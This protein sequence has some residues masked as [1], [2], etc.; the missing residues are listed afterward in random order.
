MRER[1]ANLRGVVV[2][3]LFTLGGV[4]EP[5]ATDI[6]VLP[7]VLVTSGAL[8]RGGRGPPLARD[9]R[10][11]PRWRRCRRRTLSRPAGS[12]ARRPRDADVSRSAPRAS[13]GDRRAPPGSLP[14]RRRGSAD[15][16]GLG[17]APSG[18]CGRRARNVSNVPFE[19]WRATSNPIIRARRGPL[20]VS[21]GWRCGGPTSLRLG[22]SSSAAWPSGSGRLAWSIPP[23]R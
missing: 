19:S 11:P 7:I 21:G 5:A 8:I 17:A 23:S 1:L 9:P 20:M 15:R 14:P 12:G 13:P 2:G 6:P 3:F 18:Q 22:S 16:A 10:E 4:S